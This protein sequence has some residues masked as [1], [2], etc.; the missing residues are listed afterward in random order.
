MLVQCK[1]RQ[2]IHGRLA[3]L[4]EWVPPDFM[5]RA[6]W[7]CIVNGKRMPVLAGWLKEVT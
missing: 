3:L 6:S 5:G 2:D 7:I 1:R 4:L